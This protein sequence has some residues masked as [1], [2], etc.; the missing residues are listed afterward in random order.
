MNEK[1]VALHVVVWSKPDCPLCDEVSADLAALATE[2]ALTVETRNILD[3][4]QAFA[5]YRYLIPVVEVN[6]GS[7]HYPPHDWN[8]LRAATSAARGAPTVDLTPPDFLSPVAPHG[9]D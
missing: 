9:A 5:R 3:D 7:L 8:S 4:A 1:T 6:G 2:F